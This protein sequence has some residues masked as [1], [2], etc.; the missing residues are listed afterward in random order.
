MQEHKYRDFGSLIPR[1]IRADGLVQCL[2][3][4][5]QGTRD[6]ERIGDKI[7]INSIELNYWCAS[8]PAIPDTNQV[9]MRFIVFIWND[10]TSP[11]LANML[12]GLTGNPPP[13]PN[14]GPIIPP[15][16][17]VM[18]PFDH[19][20]K[21]KRK[22][23]W[24]HTYHQTGGLLVTATLPLTLQSQGDIFFVKRQFLDLKKLP[25]AKRT[26]NFEAGGTGG[27]NKIWS[28]TLSNIPTATSDANSPNMYHF[29]RVNY[30]DG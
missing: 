10:D 3:D 7:V 12:E 1:P 30:V 25:I 18:S 6:I 27:I 8:R 13:G 26:I 4:I 21:T 9:I 15:E 28:I 29:H 20:R 14:A 24:D 2:T 19:D 16:M 17:I 5:P 23:L 22:I 11:S